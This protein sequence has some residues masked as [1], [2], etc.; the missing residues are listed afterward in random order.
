VKKMIKDEIRNNN[1]EKQSK[2]I[3]TVNAATGA[4]TLTYGDK[5]VV[6]KDN[7]LESVIEVVRKQRQNKLEQ[8]RNRTARFREKLDS[9]GK[10]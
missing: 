7:S 5:T 10:V 4:V 1:N 2:V 6:T 8:S 9:I 3:A